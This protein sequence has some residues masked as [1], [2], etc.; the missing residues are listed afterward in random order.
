ML[1]TISNKITEKWIEN[2]VINKEFKDA[3]IYGLLLL[4]STGINIAVIATISAFMHKSLLWIPFLVGFIPLRV[5][6]GGFHAK[7]PFRC[8]VFFCGGYTL[9]LLLASSMPD[10]AQIIVELI[11]TVVSAVLVYRL[12]PISASNKPLSD[13]ELLQKRKLSLFIMAII[14]FLSVFFSLGQFTSEVVLMWSVG[15]LDAAISLGIGK[16]ANSSHSF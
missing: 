1:E 5:T 14:L 11:S 13:K 8:G 4:L 10:S 16:T 12:A 6:A 3:Y 9:F 2:G 7:T 15:V